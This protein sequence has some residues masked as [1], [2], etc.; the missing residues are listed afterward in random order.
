MR[1]QQKYHWGTDE[2]RLPET[3]K[4]TEKI[5]KNLLTFN[6]PYAMMILPVKRA[7]FL[8][9]FFSS[10]RLFVVYRF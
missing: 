9:P 7:I 4:I 8:R 1:S 5:A 10:G 6:T 3:V 2:N